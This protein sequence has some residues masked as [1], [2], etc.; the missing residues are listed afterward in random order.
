MGADGLAA[1]PVAPSAMAA[2]AG[3]DAPLAAQSSRNAPSTAPTG[4]G[5]SASAPSGMSAVGVAALFAA[6]AMFFSSLLL[7][8]ARW[9]SVLVVSLIERPG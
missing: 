5:S 1:R 9:R 3:N 2:P 8:P 7:A 6:A 4:G